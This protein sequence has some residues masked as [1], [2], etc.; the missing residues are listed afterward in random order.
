MLRASEDEKAERALAV[1]QPRVVIEAM[2]DSAEEAEDGT[3]PPRPFRRLKPAYP[4]AAAHAQLEAIVD[5]FVDVDE[6]GEVSRCR[7]CALGGIRFGRVSADDRQ[8]AALLSGH[9][10]RSGNSDACAAS[11]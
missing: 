11:L 5:V 8:T 7:H 1:E 2:S 4:E 3:R 6:K 9:A 10:Q